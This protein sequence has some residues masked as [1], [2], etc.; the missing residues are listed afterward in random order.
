MVFFLQAAAV[1]NE[2]GRSD[3]PLTVTWMSEP[4]EASREDRTRTEVK[5]EVSSRESS[6]CI[7]DYSQSLYFVRVVRTCIVI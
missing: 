7:S 5:T 3:N 2:T 1:R 4:S 6:I